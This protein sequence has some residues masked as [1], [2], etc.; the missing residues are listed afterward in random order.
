GD[1]LVVTSADGLKWRFPEMNFAAKSNRQW[2]DAGPVLESA[3]AEGIVRDNVIVH[4]GTNAGVNEDQLRA[5]LDA[6]GPERN[7][8]VMNLYGSSTFVPDSNQ[9]IERV[10]ADYPHAVVGDWQ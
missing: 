9:T 6:L 1:S 3:L 7:V 4:F 5:F 10:V 8:V 2:K